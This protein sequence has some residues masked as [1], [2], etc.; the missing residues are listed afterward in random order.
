MGAP[1]EGG[2]QLEQPSRANRAQRGRELTCEKDE[3]NSRLKS[4]STV[5]RPR[6]RRQNCPPRRSATNK[7]NE[8]VKFNQLER[9]ETFSPSVL[10]GRQRGPPTRAAYEEPARRTPPPPRPATTSNSSGANELGQKPICEPEGA[11]RKRRPQVKSSDC[12]LAARIINQA[13]QFS[14]N[15]RVQ[16]AGQTDRKV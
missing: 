6:R 7:D 2:P 14:Q 13:E 15:C 3:L 5:R 4:T 16:P 10:R 8:H 1:P 12:C 9:T 11:D